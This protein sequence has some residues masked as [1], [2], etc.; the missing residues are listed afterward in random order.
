MLLDP[1]F[2]TSKVCGA[3]T[4]GKVPRPRQLAEPSRITV[5]FD[6]GEFEAVRAQAA[7]CKKSKAEIVRMAVREWA[8]S[9]QSEVH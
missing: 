7:I 5:S 9:A 3:F 2:H 4:G 8:R 1:P 6:K